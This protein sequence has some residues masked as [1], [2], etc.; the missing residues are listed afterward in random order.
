M[1]TKVATFGAGCFWG[2][3]EAF[4]PL[5]GI[6]DTKVGYMGGELKNPTYKQV[7]QGDSGHTEVIQIV[8]DPQKISY[9]RL[10][11]VFFSIHDPSQKNRQGPDVGFQYR[12]V[13]FAHDAEQKRI[14]EE[15]IHLLKQ[16][17]PIATTVE[18]EKAF[19]KAEEF[20]QKYFAKKGKE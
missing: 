15:K 18:K 7:C 5:I 14:A 11:D 1:I 13:I 20:H 17:K 8:F 2:V 19:Y 12:S 16:T 10:V 6:L 4:D 9:G 3:Q